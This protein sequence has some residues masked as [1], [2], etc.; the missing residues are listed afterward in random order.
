LFSVEN[1][2][3]S[4]AKQITP[5]L[6]FRLGGNGIAGVFCALAPSLH[7]R[8][9]RVFTWYDLKTGHGWERWLRLSSK[10]PNHLTTRNAARKYDMA[11]ALYD[12]PTGICRAADVGVE[13]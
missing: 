3:P 1:P 4:L 9:Y 5:V 7:N 2:P 8:L 13:L 12:S 6:T 11:R 10:S